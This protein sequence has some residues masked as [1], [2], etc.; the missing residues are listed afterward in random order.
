VR[1]PFRRAIRSKYV[2]ATGGGGGSFAQNPALT[3]FATSGTVKDLGLFSQNGIPYEFTA[4]C[5]FVYDP[6]RHHLIGLGGGHAASN[7]DGL[8]GMDISNAT[9]F[10][11]VYPATVDIATHHTYANYDY[12]ANGTWNVSDSTPYP[13]PA[14][15][16]TVCL[17]E[18]IN[19]DLVVVAHVEGN[20][21]TGGDAINPTGWPAYTADHLTGGNVGYSPG[22]VAHYDATG[23]AWSFASGAGKYEAWPAMAYHDA[24]GYVFVLGATYFSYYN[25][26]TKTTGLIY[27]LSAAYYLYDQDGAH[28]FDGD[29]VKLGYNSSMKRCPDDGKL[30]Y[31]GIDG[32][33]FRVDPD[34]ST[35]PASFGNGTPI[36]LMNH[37]T[38]TPGARGTSYT[39]ATWNWDSANHVFVT[40]PMDSVMYAYNPAT[41]AWSSKTLDVAGINAT[42]MCGAYDPVDNC[43]IF[44]AELTSTNYPRHVCAV[45]WG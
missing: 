36:I 38:G 11:A 32:D 3:T 44:V 37:A 24:S 8:A 16:H 29:R 25:P 31:L 14:A 15:R 30:Y 27:D 21:D 6:T 23:N 10:S 40:G 39:C 1:L 28:L 2:G 13:R 42:F 22:N 4:F 43:H 35:A 9:S 19:G 12:A 7:W 41:N 18:V 33:V 5:S 20:M 26:A 45:R 34:I 17:Q